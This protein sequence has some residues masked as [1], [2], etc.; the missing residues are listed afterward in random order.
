MHIIFNELKTMRMLLFWQ[1]TDS[2]TLLLASYTVKPLVVIMK[3]QYLYSTE[4]TI[5]LKRFYIPK[6]S[7]CVTP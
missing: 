7:L 6:C 2:C 4:W 3:F 5:A 1:Q